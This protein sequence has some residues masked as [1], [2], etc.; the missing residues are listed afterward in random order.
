M[1]L[2]EKLAIYTLDG[3]KITSIDGSQLRIRL[4]GTETKV[5]IYV[6]AGDPDE[7][8]LFL[9]RTKSMLAEIELLT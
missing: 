7:T 9:K 5:W 8:E 3:H 6:E 4:S 1:L 2:D